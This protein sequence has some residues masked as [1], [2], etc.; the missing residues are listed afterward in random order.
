MKSKVKLS[1]VKYKEFPKLMSN[2]QYNFI[3]LFEEPKKGVVLFN[4][5]KDQGFPPHYIGYYSEH[6]AMDRFEDFNG[7][8]TL[9]N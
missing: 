2:K 3:V 6:W 5:E 4:N 7:K 9:K 1:K 8:L